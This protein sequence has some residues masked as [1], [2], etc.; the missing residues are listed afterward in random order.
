MPQ[1]RPYRLV[2]YSL[3]RDYV[4]RAK[5]QSNLKTRRRFVSQRRGSHFKVVGNLD[6]S[7]IAQYISCTRWPLTVWTS[8]EPVL[9][10]RHIFGESYSLSCPHGSILRFE[11]PQYITPLQ[12]QKCL[13]APFYCA[14]FFAT[15]RV[16]LIYM[17]ANLLASRFETLLR[18]P[19]YPGST[20][21]SFNPFTEE[22]ETNHGK[23]CLQD[24]GGRVLTGG[25][26]WI[27][28]SRIVG[29]SSNPAS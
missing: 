24:F 4:D 5:L 17:R 7:A 15:N 29:S 25:S 9:R 2:V 27:R 6:P 26:R 19:I 21:H 8:E 20:A 3:G 22:L 11:T 1:Q 12:S 18:T 23:D 13:R 14:D 28:K 16:S 10:Q